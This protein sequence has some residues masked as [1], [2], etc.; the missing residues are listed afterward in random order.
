MEY[1]QI[2][3]QMLLRHVMVNVKKQ[4]GYKLSSDDTVSLNGVNN[5]PVTAGQHT[6]DIGAGANHATAYS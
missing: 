5:L 6:M 4:Y 1:P 3:L 2:L